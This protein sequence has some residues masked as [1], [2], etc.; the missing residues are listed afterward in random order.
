MMTPEEY[1]EVVK[2]QNVI[3]KKAY[4][5]INK[6][7]CKADKA[8]MPKNIRAATAK[9]MVEGN[10]IWHKREVKY[11]GPFWNIVDAVL[12][13]NDLFKAYCADDGCRYGLDGAFVK[14]EGEKWEEKK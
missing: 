14:K 1:A 13:P 6:A 4:S 7:R 10:I 5:I 12:S 11:G 9:D 3:I 2:E 8:K